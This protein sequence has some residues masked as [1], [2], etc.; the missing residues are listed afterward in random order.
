MPIHAGLHFGMEL[1]EERKIKNPTRTKD[2]HIIDAKTR[3]KILLKKERRVIV[4]QLK[5]G[6]GKKRHSITEMSY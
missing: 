2:Y 6:E 5:Y 3:N 1:G 4:G